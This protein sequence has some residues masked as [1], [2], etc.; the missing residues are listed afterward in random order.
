MKNKVKPNRR[1]GNKIL[2]TK[3]NMDFK[4][5]ITDTI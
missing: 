1:Q 3:I 4:K 2:Q 5:K